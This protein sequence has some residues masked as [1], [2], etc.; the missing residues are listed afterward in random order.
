[1]NRQGQVHFETLRASSFY[2]MFKTIRVCA[3]PSSFPIQLF[4]IQ[5]SRSGGA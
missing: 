4:R 2:T 1:V 5:R 3:H